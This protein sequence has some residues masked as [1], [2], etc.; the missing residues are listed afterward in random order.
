MAIAT[1]Y[2][3]I[4][5][6]KLFRGKIKKSMFQNYLGI[7]PI[8]RIMRGIKRKIENLRTTYFVKLMLL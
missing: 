6:K 1:V 5:S 8:T 7:P 3:L 2:F 4:L